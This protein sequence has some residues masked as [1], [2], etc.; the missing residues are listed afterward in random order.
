MGHFV[1][2]T[3]SLLFV[4]DPRRGRRAARRS[5]Q[6]VFGANRFAEK[7]DAKTYATKVQDYLPQIQCGVVDE[8][9][10]EAPVYRFFV[11]CK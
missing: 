9:S 6:S 10:R 4:S 2:A 8:F 5:A 3:I 1:F 7:A 11:I